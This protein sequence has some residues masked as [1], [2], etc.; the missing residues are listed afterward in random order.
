M[1]KLVEVL[2]GNGIA[3]ISRETLR[4]ILKAGGVSWQSTK[5]WKSSNDPEFIAK[6]S[7]VLDLYDNPPDDGRVIC[8]DEF[9]P[10]NLLP[11]AGRGWFAAGRPKR[12]RATYPTHPGCSAH[13][14]CPGPAQWPVVLP[15][16]GPETMDGVPIVSEVVAGSLAGR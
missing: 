8:V 3:D 12:L 7:R 14:R 1:S 2:R 15:D 13:V 11:R 4:V 6:M 10:L 5:T 16:P 9:G